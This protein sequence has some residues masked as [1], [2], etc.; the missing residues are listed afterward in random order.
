MTGPSISVIATYERALFCPPVHLQNFAVPSVDF[1]FGGW[2]N[3]PIKCP[4]A[5][6]ARNE[7]K[8][9]WLQHALLME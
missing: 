2:D 9:Q 4:M 6:A 8:A 1:A 7:L 3:D 5:R